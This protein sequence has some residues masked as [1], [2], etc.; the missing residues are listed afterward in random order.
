MTA[1]DA[2]DRALLDLA[3]DGRRPRCGEPDD[4]QL[5]TSESPDERRRAAQLCARCP[6]LHPC[7]DAAEEMEERWHVF[8]GVDRRPSR[9]ARAAKEK[10]A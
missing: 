5:W 3:G 10:R 7:A 9:T 6:L 2:L 8:G 4:H 1:R